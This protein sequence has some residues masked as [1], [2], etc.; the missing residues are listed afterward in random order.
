[1]QNNYTALM[2]YAEQKGIKNMNSKF[3]HDTVCLSTVCTVV[4]EH[5]FSCD[6]LLQWNLS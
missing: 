2:F 5:Y 1:M 6:G 3:L 4:L